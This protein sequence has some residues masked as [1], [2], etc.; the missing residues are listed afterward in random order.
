MPESIVN[1]V[2]LQVLNLEWNLLRGPLPSGFTGLKKLKIL[3]LS[4]NFLGGYIP[5]D[6]GEMS[7][8][9]EIH[10]NS[11]K[12]NLDSLGFVGPI[13]DSIGLLSK[14]VH[15]DLHKNR[16]TGDLPYEIGF[17]N[18]LEIINVATNEGLV[19]FVPLEYQNLANLK[20]FYIT[21]TSIEGEITD[22]LCATE[23]YIEV[24]CL[25]DGDVQCS[26]CECGDRRV[27]EGLIV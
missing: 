4:H 14:L 25:A 8:L 7:E 15:L 2:N 11:N 22:E 10:L 23:A 12:G 13:P 20:E 18:N 24:S 1:L 6:I 27:L 9:S 3:N 17:L 5:A 19:G 21:G 16:L 26:C